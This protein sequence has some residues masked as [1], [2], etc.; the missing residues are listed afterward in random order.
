MR[1]RTYLGALISGLAAAASVVILMAQAPEAPTAS[2]PAHLKLLQTVDNLPLLEA[3]LHQVGVGHGT[4]GRKHTSYSCWQ[5]GD[6]DVWECTVHVSYDGGAWLDV[7]CLE[8]E[9]RC[10]LSRHP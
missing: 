7:H 3:W 1:T 8:S 9:G 4:V 2:Q 10:W 5:G 6:M